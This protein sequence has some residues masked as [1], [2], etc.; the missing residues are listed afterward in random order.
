MESLKGTLSVVFS[1][2]K[3]KLGFGVE[4]KVLFGEAEL[5]IDAV[6]EYGDFE[7]KVVN[8]KGSKDWD[9]YYE[10]FKKA[11]GLYVDQLIN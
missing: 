2:G 5:V 11:V 3:R 7:Y 9:D 4:G 8:G 10:V 1:N 6:D